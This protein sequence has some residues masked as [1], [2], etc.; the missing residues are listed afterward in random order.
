M[1]L[2][3]QIEAER[4]GTP[5]LV[6]RDG[7]GAQQ[8]VPLSPARERIT[9]GR[10]DVT[11]VPLTWDTSVSRVHAELV[12]VAGDWTVA[13]DGLSRYGSY[14][15]GQRLTGRRRLD[16]GDRIQLGEVVLV[17]RQP[18]RLEA[19]GDDAQRAARRS[20][21]ALRR[22]APRARRAVPAVRRR[23]A[24]RDAGLAT[25]RSPTSCSSASPR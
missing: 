17:Y 9:L 11:D 19:D 16:D 20:D 13:D 21:R 15:N 5:F 22:P 7:D 1:E 25:S 18:G 6:F 23:R 2:K 14:V 8:I 12:R 4:E 3:A 24:L 10:I